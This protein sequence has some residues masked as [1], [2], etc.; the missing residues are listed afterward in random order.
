MGKVEKVV[1]DA[2]AFISPKSVFDCAL[3]A[4]AKFII[5]GDKGL[6]SIKQFRGVKIITPED[7]LKGNEFHR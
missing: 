7:F 4:K 5:T 3:S 6:L 2:N 1:I